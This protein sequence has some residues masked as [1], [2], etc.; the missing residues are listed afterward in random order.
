MQEVW[1]IFTKR[2]PGA[3]H[4][5]LPE[6][7]LGK[8]AVVALLSMLVVCVG[9]FLLCILEP[10][11]DFIRLLFEEVSAFGTVGLST[12]ITPGLTVASKVV[13]ILTMY[14]GRLGAFTLVSIWINRAEPNIRYTQESI[15]IG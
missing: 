11:T 14:V 13:L 15:T 8:S 3:F 10:D 2:R 1:A 5:T 6:E 4:R 9:T 7:T 12:G